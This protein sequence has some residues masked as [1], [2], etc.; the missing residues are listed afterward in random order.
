MDL[1]SCTCGVMLNRDTM[2]FPRSI[3]LPEDPDDENTWGIV[4]PDKAVFIHGL[5]QFAA[6]ARCPVCDAKVPRVGDTF[7]GD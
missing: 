2:N 6:L 1:Y 3:L 5:G 7:Y 4:D